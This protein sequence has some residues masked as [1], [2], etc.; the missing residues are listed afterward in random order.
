M[1]EPD[2]GQPHDRTVELRQEIL[3]FRN[4]IFKY[5]DESKSEEARRL[6]T[7]LA[8]W[9]LG[10]SFGYK[11]CCILEFCKN[12]FYGTHSKPL[13]VCPKTKAVFCSFCREVFLESI[14]GG[15]S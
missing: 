9:M 3:N 2:I 15:F 10:H 13:V 8:H 14:T 7:V 1:D 11:T 6:A 12:T 4:E 5:A